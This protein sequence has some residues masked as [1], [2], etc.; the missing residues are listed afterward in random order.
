MATRGEAQKEA[1]RRLAARGSLLGFAE[2]V[3]PGWTT[4]EHH[5]RICAALESVF[6]GDTKRLMIFAPPRHT[7]SLL[8]S[9]LFPAWWMGH[10]PDSQIICASHTADLAKDF[11]ADVR[12]LVQDQDYRNVFADVTLTHEPLELDPDAKA[13]GRWRTSKGGVYYAVG[14]DGAVAGRGANLAIIDDPVKG[15][16]EAE[17]PRMRH[18]AWRWYLG[19]MYQRLMPGGAIVFMMTR[20]HEDDLAARAL[21]SDDWTVLELPAIANEHTDHEAALWPE[22]WPLEELR[23]KREVMS[24]GARLREWKAQYQQQPTAEEGTYILREWFGDR[25][26]EAP[27]HLNVFIASDFAVT[28]ALEGSD[29]DY[30]EHGVFGVDPEDNLYVLDWWTGR[31]TPDVW[32]SALF[33]LI[34]KWEPF[35]WFGEAGVIRR[36]IQ[37]LIEKEQEERRQYIRAEYIPSIASK[38]VR[39]RAFQGRA[40]SGR[41]RFGRQPFAD[42]VVDQCVAFPGDVHDDAFDVMSLMCLVIDQAH[43]ATAPVQKKRKRRDPYGAGQGGG[44]WKTA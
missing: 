12:N 37:P 29:P 43:P 32:V 33:D 14:V 6:R 20:W 8:A 11:G 2:Y 26:D 13:A 27:E 36:A 23:S 39:G 40:A 1:R 4:G 34:D 31:T 42:R 25:Y 21:S 18:L 22:W 15:R 41:V 28:E 38:A 30:T 10:R 9:R 3:H 24:R 17:S 7:K 44:G 16:N 5:K 35:A 19:D